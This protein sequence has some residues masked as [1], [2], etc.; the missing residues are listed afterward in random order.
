MDEPFPAAAILDQVLDAAHLDAVLLAE[1]TQLRQMSHVAIGANDFT[2][3]AGFL[4]PGQGGEIDAAFGVAG[5]DQDAALASAQ[6]VDVAV[7]ANQVI[8]SGTVVDGDANGP[9]T[10]VGRSPR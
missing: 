2:N 9:R 10:I 3:H 6:A 7:T 1:F 4:E 8:R 5:A